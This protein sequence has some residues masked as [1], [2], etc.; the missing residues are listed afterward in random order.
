VKQAKTTDQLERIIRT[1]KTVVLLLNT[2]SKRGE[3][4]VEEVQES[5]R[6][7]GYAI[8]AVHTFDAHSRLEEIMTNIMATPPSLLVVGSGDGTV[9]TL[10][11]Y[12][13]YTDTALGYIPLGT[14]NNFGRSLGIPLD[15]KEAVDVITQGKL[16]AVNLGMVNGDYFANMATFGV[17]MIVA[18]GV[19]HS[20]K[21]LFGR[22]SYGI[23]SLISIIKHRP[24]NVDIDTG[25]DQVTFKTHQLC[26]A[27]GSRHAGQQI[28][29]DAHIDKNQLLAYA[30]GSASR[31]S[32]MASIIHHLFSSHLP[33]QQKGFI[34]SPNLTV[35]LS[36][37]QRV[38][39]DGEVR[40]RTKHATY[41]FGVAT[42][43]LRVFVPT[44]FIDL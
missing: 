10:T 6:S 28:A 22:A 14:T 25:T 7:A 3:R 2:H 32:T 12:L 13:A 34:A 41:E 1:D 37:P 31:L 8:Q 16:A 36:R 35:G 33:A 24:L 17:S 42:D 19:P 5:I 11:R 4:S 21:Q 26:I 39:I 18:Q 27:N 9:S 15:I 43:A 29:S 30:L 20:L 40:D 23:Y 38:E 44:D